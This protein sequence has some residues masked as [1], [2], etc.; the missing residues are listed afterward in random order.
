LRGRNQIS[1]VPAACRRPG[2]YPVFSHET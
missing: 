2:A 1:A